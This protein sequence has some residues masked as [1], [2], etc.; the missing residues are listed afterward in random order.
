MSAVPSSLVAHALADLIGH[1]LVRETPVA[2]PG[3]G[4]FWRR[5]RPGHLVPSSG[6]PVVTPPRD[7]VAFTP[8]A[9]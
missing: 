7:E 6:R 2:V 9:R 1:A 8:E 3:L 4:T 5:H